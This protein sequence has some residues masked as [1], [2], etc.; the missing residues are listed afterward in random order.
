MSVTTVFVDLT[1][2]LPQLVTGVCTAAGA[3]TAGLG[4]VMLSHRY[5]EHE[6]ARERE[7]ATNTNIEETTR[8]LFDAVTE[9]HLAV[10]THQPMHN[11]WLPRMMPLGS[12][13]LEFMAGSQSGGWAVGAV[14]S[15]RIAVEATNSQNLAA[16]ALI[17]PV[18]RVVAA[19]ARASLLPDGSVRSAALRLGEIAVEAAHAYGTDNLWS[20]QKSVAARAAADAA[21]FAALRDLVDTASSH[22]HPQAHPRRRWPVRWALH[23]RDGRRQAA[24]APPVAVPQ[25]RDDAR[26][27]I[28]VAAASAVGPTSAAAAAGAAPESR[29]RHRP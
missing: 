1:P 21:L 29:I 23:R 11:A 12:S 15:S 25:A 18:Q 16:L 24:S 28:P 3:V 8:E 10:S 14:R 6:R 17:A 7:S 20:R 9:L 4:T 26:N 5:N 2:V 27:T 22:L 19:A 13:M